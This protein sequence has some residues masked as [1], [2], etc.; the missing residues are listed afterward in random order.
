MNELFDLVGEYRQLYE[1][2]TEDGEEQIIKDTM[3]GVQ[4]EIEIKAEGLVTICNRLDMEIEACK[5]HKDEWAYREKIRKNARSRI[6]QLFINAMTAMDVKE[7]KAGDITVKMK[8][9]GGKLGLIV[10]DQ[11]TIP[12][13]YTKLTIE[14]DNDLIREALDRGEKLDFAHY[15]DRTKVIKFK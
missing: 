2:L 13:K 9:A 15:A 7:L 1:M 5:K 6:N 14:P 11:A 3:E 12:E 4:G 8:N 10:D